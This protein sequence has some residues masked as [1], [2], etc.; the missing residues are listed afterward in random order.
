MAFASAAVKVRGSGQHERSKLGYKIY[1]RDISGTT[2]FYYDDCYEH[3][4][5]RDAEAGDT[6]NIHFKPQSLACHRAFKSRI[7]VIQSVSADVTTTF[8]FIAE[9]TA[10][11]GE[12]CSVNDQTDGA[13]VSFA[14]PYS[15]G[16]MTFIIEGN[17]HTGYYI[18]Q[19][20]HFD[21]TGSISEGALADKT[22]TGGANIT[23]S[24]ADPSWTID[25][26]TISN[27]VVAG[28]G[29]TIGASLTPGPPSTT[30]YTVGLSHP[31]VMTMG[32]LDFVGSAGTYDVGVTVAGTGWTELNPN[33]GAEVPT[34]NTS[35]N[36]AF[37]VQ[38]ATT[39]R[40][41]YV[42]IVQK[43]FHAAFSFTFETSGTNT[44]TQL[45]LYRNGVYEAAREYV[46]FFAGANDYNTVAFH[47]LLTVNPNDYFSFYAASGG[48][49][50]LSFTKVNYIFVGD[51][52]P[53]L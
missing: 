50:T 7:H 10:T 40:L 48:T 52:M 36:D 33:V 49:E 4:F 44:L 27:T 21:L 11:Y 46:Q 18:S 42:G 5:L 38:G 31:M 41:Q 22:L 8:N 35:G 34:I 28:T 17:I 47:I 9:P 20:A 37:W 23:V 3:Y 29:I 6:Y 1:D 43:K 45:R 30:E 15:S 53:A 2:S 16:V 32:E 39:G 13:T 24:G 25:S 51:S 26:D 19:D 12:V 14:G